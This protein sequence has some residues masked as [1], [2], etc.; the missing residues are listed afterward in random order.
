MVSFLRS[1]RQSIPGCRTRAAT[2]IGI[3]MLLPLLLS[4]CSKDKS[5][6]GPGTYSL[7]GNVVLVGALVDDGGTTLGEQVVTN[8]DG[9]EVY[10][11]HDGVLADSTST[12]DGRYEFH[13][14]LGSYAAFARVTPS[15][16]SRTTQVHVHDA[17]RVF[18]DTITFRSTAALQLRPNPMRTGGTARYELTASQLVRLEVRDLSGALVQTLVTGSE[19][20]GTYQVVWDG[21]TN[22]GALAPKGTYWL[23]LEGET[24][25]ALFVVFRDLVVITGNVRLEG[26]LF[27]EFGAPAGT[28]VVDDANGV[29]VRLLGPG[30]SEDSVLTV[31]GR[32]QFGVLDPGLYRVSA[33]VVAGRDIMAEFPLSTSDVTVP[34]T[35]KLTTFG[36]IG[37]PPN[38]FPAEHGVGVEFTLDRDRATDIIV[39]DLG[40]TVWW[41]YSFL[42]PVGFNH[43]HWN[44]HDNLDRPVANGSY[45]TIVQAEDRVFYNLVF[46]E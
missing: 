9:V 33:R 27:G 7:S 12:V 29:R 16:V 5:A 25:H 36:E 34:D 6:T 42:A 46:K 13:V 30:G 22:L 8:A 3:A 2:S 45:W 41:T 28:R 31:A 38:P 1:S 15:I 40:G 19:A 24:D 10:L 4:A 18:P 43:I 20:A 39:T 44:G 23:V 17:A 35:L 11:E 26:A 37:N 21:R 32:Y 14:P